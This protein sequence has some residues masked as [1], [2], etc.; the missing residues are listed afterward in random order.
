[1]HRGFGRAANQGDTMKRTTFQRAAL[2]LTAV[3][4]M[5]SM[6][7]WAVAS[8]QTKLGYV[9]VLSGP[10]AAE[11]RARLAVVEEAVRRFELFNDRS[12]IEVRE[13]DLHKERP[14]H[15]L[16]QV[17]VAI[18][19]TKSQLD[20]WVGTGIVTVVG[21]MI[22]DGQSDSVAGL[23]DTATAFVPG[24]AG[25]A[26]TSASSTNAM[27]LRFAPPAIV[28]LSPAAVH[29]YEL[30]TIYL[31]GFGNGP[32]GAAFADVGSAGVTITNPYVDLNSFEVLG[33]D[34]S[35]P[36]GTP[37]GPVRLSVPSLGTPAI[38]RKLESPQ[39]LVVIDVPPPPPP[40]PPPTTSACDNVSFVRLGSPN[41]FSEIADSKDVVIANYD[42]D[43]TIL[44][45]FIP[46]TS[47]HT[48]TLYKGLG[49]DAA[50]LPNFATI[51]SILTN[52]APSKRQYGGTA[53]DIDGDGDLDIVPSGATNQGA[54]E[55]VRLLINNAN[56][57]F[58]NE[59][60]TRITNYS[61]VS[62]PNHSWDETALA[63]VDGDGDLDIALANR[64][65][66]GQFSALLLNLGSFPGDPQEGTFTA[67]PSAFGEPQSHV[68]HDVAF[69]DIDNDGDPDV[70]LSQDMR[71]TQRPLQL[72]LNQ[73]DGNPATDTPPSFVDATAQ[74]SNNPNAHTQH[75][76]CVDFDNNGWLDIHAGVWRRSDQSNNQDL[77]FMNFTSD[78]NGNGTIEAS[79]IVLTGIVD[80]DPSSA[81]GIG[82]KVPVYS[83]AY[84]DFNGDGLVDIVVGSNTGPSVKG[85][86]MMCNN[87]NGTFTNF[88]PLNMFW[89]DLS[90]TG[91]D[92][93]NITSPD[94]ADLNGD[95]LLDIVFGMGDGMNGPFVE[96]NRIYVQKASSG[97]GGPPHCEQL[98]GVG[99]IFQQPCVEVAATASGMVIGSSGEARLAPLAGFCSKA[100]ECP[101]CGGPFLPCEKRFDLVLDF[102]SVGLNPARFDVELIDFDGQA[103]S[104]ETRN[105][106]G[107]KVISFTPRGAF[108]AGG[109]DQQ[110]LIKIIAGRG[111][112]GEGVAVPVALEVPN[113]TILF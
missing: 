2:A 94:V 24:S 109:L 57:S 41:F 15:R 86:F 105:L 37:S 97:G 110:L 65:S 63:D 45:V 102:G 32:D 5:L 20:D 98:F 93:F 25:V 71:G 60:T 78:T 49:N 62:G 61:A 90:N 107:R 112:G 39:Q 56:L 82:F 92:H 17:D 74:L 111:A 53:G 91:F 81:T 80:P 54:S 34:I 14:E 75:V 51:G 31:E 11:G 87:G 68:H 19:G 50:G 36:P 43:D 26:I 73:G 113:D 40:P 99:A 13:I 103:A 88:A 95:G 42:T 47:T 76:A 77:I 59:G 106:G 96:A 10:D 1:M 104:F 69:C 67:Y 3:G 18:F 70:L 7:S 16:K 33:Y 6:A 27:V 89:R 23:L 21:E 83:A 100:F 30:S 79:E 101:S 12:N 55:R 9:D 72:K 84:G 85:P 52:D 64:D 66:F 58:T 4:W 46:Q 48:E 44:D 8:D 29:P 38:N 35:V 28:S 22:R 108:R